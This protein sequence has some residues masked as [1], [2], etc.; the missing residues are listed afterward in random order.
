MLN[1]E[2]YQQ[3]IHRVLRIV[4]QRP[5]PRR[6]TEPK[7]DRLTD[8]NMLGSITSQKRLFYLRHRD[9]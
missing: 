3:R 7:R 5:V 1:R 4:P 8:I 6:R 9:L 2:F